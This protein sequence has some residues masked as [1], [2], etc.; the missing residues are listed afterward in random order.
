MKT[1][2]MKTVGRRQWRRSG[3]FIVTCEHVSQFSLITPFNR[4]TFAGLILK[5][6][7]HL[8]ARSGISCVM[9]KYFQCEQNL[10]TNSITTLQLD[11]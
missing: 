4:E 10:L 2:Q 1:V 7:T 11:Q 6:Q 8:K 5:I 3:V 9:L